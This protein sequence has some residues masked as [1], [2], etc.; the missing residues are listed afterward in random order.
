ME[1]RLN[2]KTIYVGYIASYYSNL[3]HQGFKIIKNFNC[4][5]FKI[6]IY[7]M[8]EYFYYFKG[9]LFKIGVDN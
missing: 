8:F 1:F 4:K 6:I 7:Y 3:L 2:L 5:R 9:R